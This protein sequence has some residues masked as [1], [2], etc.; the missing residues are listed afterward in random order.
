VRIMNFALCH[1]GTMV[2]VMG[3]SAAPALAQTCATDADCTAPLTCK[4]GYGSCTGGGGILPDGV[5]YTLPTVCQSAPATCTWVF[6]ACQTDS[7][8][9]L[10]NWA[11][12]EFPG[13]GNVQTCFPKYTPCSATKPCLAA[14][15]CMTSAQ[16]VGIDPGPFWGMR[17]LRNPRAANLDA[18]SLV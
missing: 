9:T 2:L 10:P 18:Q 15:S 17:R 5:M 14:W 4:P 7:A 1:V 11:C 6:V 13:Q 3:A 16:P 12:L 8:C